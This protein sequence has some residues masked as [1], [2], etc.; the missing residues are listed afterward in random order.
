M[1]R[2][3]L[4]G[5]LWVANIAMA[6]TA[7]PPDIAIVAQARTPL[8]AAAR[9][10]A[11]QHALLWEGDT[12]EVRGQRLDFLQVYDHRRERAGFVRAAQVRRLG[13][14]PEVAPDLLAI[15]R[16]LRDSPGAEALGIGYAA[17]YLQA[18][19]AEAI[20]AELFD[21]LG[22]MADR[23]ARRASINRNPASAEVLAAHLDVVAHYGVVV[24]SFEHGGRMQLCYDG[25]ALRRVLALPASAEQMARAAL[26]LT[27]PECVD[28]A[29]TPRDRSA[30]DDWRAEVLD[31][32]PR[33]DLPEH[34]RNRL[35]MRSAAVWASIA[36]QR[37]RRGESAEDAAKRALSELASVNRQELAEEDRSA[38]S[39][40]AVRVGASRWA[41][42]PT[43]SKSKGLAVTVRAGAEP[44]ETCVLLIDEQHG[45]SKPLLQRCTFATVWVNSARANAAGT[46]LALAVQPLDSWR[47]L[48]VFQRSEA[49]WRVDI[50]PP[51]GDPAEPGY[52]EFAGWVPGLPKLLAARE[53]KSE[54]RFVQSFE[55]LDLETLAVE[56]HADNP[57]YLSVFY[58][59]QDAAWKKQTVSLR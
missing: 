47:E 44:G 52:L 26:A 29:L 23:L 27:R 34:L 46:A 32:V 41:A 56:K 59:W 15:V 51:G 48:W 24:R 2:V 20:G 22:T 40:A 10:S 35:R 17:A 43:S 58:R 36:F 37:G 16:F 1:R 4:L 25:E 30:L 45:P 7:A 14:T 53:S 19:P 49:G 13:L 38:Y 55:V 28:P 12:L 50:A 31:R 8:R 21:A 5:L 18:A 3:V 57:A 9:E 42:E 6:S 33:L 39:D 54:G 11:Q